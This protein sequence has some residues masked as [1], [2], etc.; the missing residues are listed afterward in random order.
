MIKTLCLLTILWLVSPANAEFYVD[1]QG[2]KRDPNKVLAEK[3]DVVSP[4][5]YRL[6]TDGLKGLIYEVGQRSAVINTSTFGSDVEF[7]YAIGA[8]IPEG[9]SAYVD[10]NILKLKNISFSA[11]DEP[12][13]NV[14]AR[15]GARFGYKYV[16]N[17]DHLIVQI[18]LDEYYMEPDQNAPITV[19]GPEGEL[20]YI[21]KT[22]QSVDKGYII[23]DGEMLPLKIK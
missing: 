21:Y 9:W 18:S 13:L 19:A 6:L 20:Y 8:I 1:H 22:K 16:V 15:V 3:H 10:E 14:L 5:G 11:T 12:W 17:W 23:I 2:L 7:K 4:N